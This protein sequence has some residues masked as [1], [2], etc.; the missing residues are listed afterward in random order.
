MWA[1]WIN[2]SLIFQV[3]IQKTYISVKGNILHS[4][5]V[6]KVKNNFRRRVF[7]CSR[8]SSNPQFLFFCCEVSCCSSSNLKS[9]KRQ[10]GIRTSGTLLCYS[11]MYMRLFQT[12]TDFTDSYIKD[13]EIGKLPISI[14]WKSVRQRNRGFA[15]TAWS[16]G[17][18]IVEISSLCN[19]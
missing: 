4:Y 5:S 7:R 12:G 1:N 14:T 16:P 11:D 17:F 19:A 9:I 15:A 13:M 18:F 10:K 6:F 3:S 8:W 2:S